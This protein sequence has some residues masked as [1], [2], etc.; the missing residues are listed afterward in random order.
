LLVRLDDD[1]DP[2]H[3]DYTPAV[4]DLIAMGEPAIGPTLPYL[5]SENEATR[6]H[7]ER[8]IEGVILTMH[9]FVFGRGWS[10][11]NAEEEFRSF[12]KT[13]WDYEAVGRKSLYESAVTE[14]QAYIERVKRWLAG[15]RVTGGAAAG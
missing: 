15:R 9:G 6:L 3:F 12:Y 2:L 7:A 14:R 11:Q 8:V 5:L 1:P 4:H 10:R 13:L